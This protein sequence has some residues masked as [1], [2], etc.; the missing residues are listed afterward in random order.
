MIDAHRNTWWAAWRQKFNIPINDPRAQTVTYAQ[1]RYDLELSLT[2]EQLATEDGFRDNEA[3]F[4]A[5][6]AEVRERQ[7]LAAASGPTPVAPEVADALDGLPSG[8][9]DKEAAMRR[10]MAIKAGALTPADG[11]FMVGQAPA[12]GTGDWEAVEI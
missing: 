7:A 1:A 2:E 4:E 5:Q 3:W 11:V 10:I 9:D 8:N 12:A 6:L